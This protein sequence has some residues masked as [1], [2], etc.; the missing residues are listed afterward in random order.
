MS[1][2]TKRRR[3]LAVSATVSGGGGGENGISSSID[4]SIS[5]FLTGPVSLM[6]PTSSSVF[7]ARA[8]VVVVAVLLITGTETVAADF[9]VDF[10]F[11][12]AAALSAAAL[13]SAVAFSAAA[14]A[15][16]LA[17]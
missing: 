7:G 11:A 8:V 4:V 10:A 2:W 5:S 17:L 15:S 12:S 3:S 1:S 14:F 9:A 16:A 13:A 6:R